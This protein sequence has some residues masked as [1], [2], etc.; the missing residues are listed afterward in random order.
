MPLYILTLDLKRPIDQYRDLT[1]GIDECGQCWRA[2]ETVWF[3]SSTWP[4][5]QIATHL[6]KLLRANDIIFV[7]AVGED[8]A[9][10]GFAPGASDWLRTRAACVPREDSRRELEK[11]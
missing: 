7:A 9:W 1:Q 10:S 2:M 4:A 6:K 8:S 11:L 3:I 5:A